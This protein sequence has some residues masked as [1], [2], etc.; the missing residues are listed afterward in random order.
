MQITPRR[1]EQNRLR[2]DIVAL[3][4]GV[5]AFTDSTNPVLL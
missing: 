4:L 3:G 5:R 2:H 1:D